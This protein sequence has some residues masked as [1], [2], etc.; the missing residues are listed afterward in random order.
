MVAANQYGGGPVGVGVGT[1]NSNTSA[2]TVQAESSTTE[3]LRA[4]SNT[5]STRII[6]TVSGRVATS[7][8]KT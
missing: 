8:R 6:R 1:V 5:R 3:A 2:N 7:R 4:S